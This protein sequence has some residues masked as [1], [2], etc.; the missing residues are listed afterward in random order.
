[1]SG[2]QHQIIFE[3]LPDVASL[4]PSEQELLAR[5]LQATD[6]AYAPFSRFR[7]GCAVRLADGSIH[8]GNNQENL[9][10]PSALCAERTVMYHLGSHGL[11]GE[12]RTIAIRAR[13][14]LKEIAQP[15]TPC[16]ACRQVLVEYERMSPE[17]FVLLMQGASGDILRMEGVEA[18]LLPFAF[19]IDF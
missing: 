9:A 18:C 16:G 17:P 19:A 2:H 14:E 8:T 1:L 5:A 15:V 6:G 7:V 13:S 11:A 4:S 3:R 12:V 10:F